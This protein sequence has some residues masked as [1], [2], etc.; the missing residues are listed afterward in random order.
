MRQTRFGHA[1]AIA[2]LSQLV[3]FTVAA[4]QHRGTR[5]DYLRA[6]Q[7]LGGNAQE[8]VTDDA[9]QPHWLP[10]SADHFWFR[11]RTDHGYEFVIVDAATGTRRPAFDH[12]RL[13]AALSLA[14]DT[15][16]DPLKL[17]FR[18]IHFVNGERA[19]RFATG[20]GKTWQCDLTTY[21]CVGPDGEPCAPGCC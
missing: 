20:K 9:V 8:L 2:A 11:N 15:A 10:G 1:L 14:S 4:A 6:E 12:G 7:F 16:M 17:S 19:V 18:D 3:A 13:A 21:A 5:A